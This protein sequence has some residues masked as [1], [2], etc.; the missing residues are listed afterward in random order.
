MEIN[1]SDYYLELLNVSDPDF[2]NIKTHIRCMF[3]FE[4]GGASKEKSKELL[5]LEELIQSNMLRNTFPIP[6][7]ERFAFSNEKDVDS[8]RR[9]ENS[10]GKQE[11]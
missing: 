10:G 11:K 3:D 5:S 1:S 6:K 8:T 9:S 2:E 7:E 4:I